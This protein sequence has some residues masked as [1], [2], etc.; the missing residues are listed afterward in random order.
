[1]TSRPTVV[2]MVPPSKPE[3]YASVMGHIT[4]S[5]I[6]ELNWEPESIDL[7]GLVAATAEHGM[8]GIYFMEEIGINTRGVTLLVF[9]GETAASVTFDEKVPEECGIGGVVLP[10]TGAV[11]PAMRLPALDS[12]WWYDPLHV[13]YAAVMYAGLVQDGKS[14]LSQ[15]EPR[16]FVASR[17][18]WN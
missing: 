2:Y 3:I 18:T 16:V 5:V 15:E 10:E 11:M 8:E 9:W 13:E 4:A 14:K 1:M 12:D 6:E 17:S 7:I